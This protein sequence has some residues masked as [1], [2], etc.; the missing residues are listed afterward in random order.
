MCYIIKNLQHLK[1]FEHYV[2]KIVEIKE[3]IVSPLDYSLITLLLILPV[4]IATF[5]IAF[6][7]INIPKNNLHN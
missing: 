5:E 4:N 1:D 3:N 6:S 7:V 2:E